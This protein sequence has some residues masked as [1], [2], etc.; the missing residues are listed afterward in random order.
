MPVPGSDRFAVAKLADPGDVR[1]GDVLVLDDGFLYEVTTGRTLARSNRA[2][3]RRAE[4]PL[5]RYLE[6]RDQPSL[7]LTRMR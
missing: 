3:S 5:D 2:S 4:V 1:T 6:E 7:P